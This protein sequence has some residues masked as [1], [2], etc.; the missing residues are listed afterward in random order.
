[1]WTREERQRRHEVLTR[2]ALGLGSSPL[3]P[4]G[5]LTD[6]SNGSVCSVRADHHV[7]NSRCPRVRQGRRRAARRDESVTRTVESSIRDT[8]VGREPLPGSA[9]RSRTAGSRIAFD[10]ARG[11]AGENAR[12]I[13]GHRRGGQ[14]KHVVMVLTGLR[15]GDRVDAVVT[16]EMVTRRSPT[17]W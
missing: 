10:P 3:A 5:R 6:S 12:A 7:A 9:C 8:R 14:P 16:A 13:P 15:R 2:A 11:R 4:P 1:V 17:G